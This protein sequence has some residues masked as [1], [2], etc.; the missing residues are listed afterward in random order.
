MPQDEHFRLTTKD[1][2]ILEI[3]LDRC[4][5]KG[6]PTAMLLRRKLDNATVLFWEDMP[7]DVVTLSSHVTYRVDD[8]AAET[9]I[10]T[11]D[12]MRGMVGSVLPISNP[13]G[14]ALLGLSEGQGMSIDR[15]GGTRET[16][17]AEMI[18]YQPEAAK[19]EAQR[20]GYPQA[21]GPAT[22]RPPYLRIVARSDVPAAARPGPGESGH[23]DPGPSAA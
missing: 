16:V 3:M 9:R 22:A 4:Q 5:D 6:S 18:A 12:E 7:A 2:T 21:G 13:R 17:T 20:L 10:I 14:L 1:C 8:G 23:D 15:P 19:R 11:H